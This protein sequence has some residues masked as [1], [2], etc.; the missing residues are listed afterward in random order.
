MPDIKL[1]TVWVW[2]QGSIFRHRA[3]VPDEIDLGTDEGIA[4]A[5]VAA[6]EALYYRYA[7][8]ESRFPIRVELFDSAEA[9][10][11]IG[12]ITVGY[13]LKDTGED[14]VAVFAQV[15]DKAKIAEPSRSE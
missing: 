8:D 15:K 9:K 3:F 14:I 2:F 7:I 5:T 10:E 1:K 11:P 4:Q 13:T 6:A 12:A